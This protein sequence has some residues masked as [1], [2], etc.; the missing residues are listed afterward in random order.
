MDTSK[1]FRGELQQSRRLQIIIITNLEMFSSSK[2]F[3]PFKY[4]TYNLKFSFHMSK[5][6]NH[7]YLTIFI[8]WV[9]SSVLVSL[10]LSKAIACESTNWFGPHNQQ[11]I[12]H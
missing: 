12:P 2:L 1:L 5:G 10:Y 9:P 3:H 11:V 8:K 6:F 7:W 4:A